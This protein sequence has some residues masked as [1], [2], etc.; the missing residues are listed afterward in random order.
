MSD[1]QL[2]ELYRGHRDE[3]AFRVLLARYGPLVLG[4]CRRV[5]GHDQDAEDA[6][7]A[8][9]LVLARRAADIR[10]GASL[11]NWL[12]GVAARLARQARRLATRQQRRERER[13]ARTALPAEPPCLESLQALDEELAR[14]PEDLR[15]P[16]VL[17]YLAGRS[18]QQ[19][20][21]ELGLS[22]GTLRRRLA[23]GRERLRGRLLRRGLAPAALLAATAS[24][25]S[26]LPKSLATDAV[27]AAL[28]GVVPVTVLT[29]AEKGL[30]TMFLT[31]TQLGIGCLALILCL[32]GGFV[33]HQTLTAQQPAGEKPAD[34]APSGRGRANE[35][36]GEDKAMRPAVPPDIER[37]LAELEK[38]LEGAL[39]EVKALRQALKT[40]RGGMTA[41]P[42]KHASADNAVEVIRAAYPDGQLRITRDDQTNTV[43]VQ[44]TPEG[45]QAVR[46][47][48][49]ALDAKK[50]ATDTDKYPSNKKP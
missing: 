17:C 23:R 30:Q 39:D 45:I 49:E 6:F 22:F 25:M 10:E 44:G 35:L 28:G 11:G 36:F 16:L 7:Q 27:R 40:S 18:Q 8:T 5:L 32:G 34:S 2:L 3:S 48:L 1:H 33:A 46:R 14:L 24:A 41:F 47:L 4:V 21:R 38:R 37:R 29:L 42:L 19:A 13:A 50:Q 20:A 9:F 43:Y 31:R 12:H 15:A 26:A